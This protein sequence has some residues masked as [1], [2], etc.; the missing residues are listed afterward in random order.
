MTNKNQRQRFR[1]YTAPPLHCVHY[2]GPH[3]NRAAAAAATVVK[4]FVILTGSIASQ[5]FSIPPGPL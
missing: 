4:R 5:R 3:N 2:Y 1:V